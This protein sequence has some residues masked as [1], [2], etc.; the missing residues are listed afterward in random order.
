MK[1]FHFQWDWCTYRWVIFQKNEIL[2]FAFLRPGS[3]GEFSCNLLRSDS[4]KYFLL[5]FP[6]RFLLYFFGLFGQQYSMTLL[7]AEINASSGTQNCESC[8]WCIGTFFSSGCGPSYELISCDHNGLHYTQPC[9]PQVWVWNKI[10]FS[11][12]QVENTTIIALSKPRAAAMFI[13]LA[14]P[15]GRMALEMC[16]FIV[17]KLKVRS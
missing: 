7:G 9:A 16:P 3:P 6:V 14:Q 15:W 5:F 11:F 1:C 8:G 12:L 10:L 2:L 13:H 4:V 17:M